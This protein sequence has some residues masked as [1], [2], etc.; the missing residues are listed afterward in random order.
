MSPILPK[1]LRVALKLEKGRA[2]DCSVGR[3]QDLTSTQAGRLVELQPEYYSIKRACEF[4]N[5]SQHLLLHLGSAGRLA[6]FVNGSGLSGYWHEIAGGVRSEEKSYV[7][8]TSGFLRL[9]R[10]YIG[11]IEANG[12]ASIPLLELWDCFDYPKVKMHPKESQECTPL[13]LDGEVL[14]YLQQPIL[15]KT[16]DVILMKPLPKVRGSDKAADRRA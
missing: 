1:R 12:N 16:T 3:F 13:W 7:E 11:Q 2:S 5:V 8:L 15:V 9:P 6:L 10:Q 14:F 4:L